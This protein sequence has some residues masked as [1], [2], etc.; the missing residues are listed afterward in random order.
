MRTGSLCGTSARTLAVVLIPH[1]DLRIPNSTRTDIAGRLARG[2]ALAEVGGEGGVAAG[3]PASVGDHAGDAL[4]VLAADV[5]EQ[6]REAGGG[7]RRGRQDEAQAEIAPP[8]ADAE[9]TGLLG[10]A[11]EEPFEFGRRAV[12]VGGDGDRVDLLEVA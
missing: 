4:L 9:H 6:A 11:E 8:G 12:E 1:S 10:P 3:A 2:Q 5:V 7:V